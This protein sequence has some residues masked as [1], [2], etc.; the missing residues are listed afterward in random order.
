MRRF[1]PFDGQMTLLGIL[2]TVVEQV[3][4]AGDHETHGSD[5]G[6]RVR[7]LPRI[8]GMGTLSVGLEPA[9]KEG[10]EAPRAQGVVLNIEDHA[11]PPLQL[12][13]ELR[14]HA[15]CRVLETECANFAGPTGPQ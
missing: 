2:H 10:M 11:A 4:L 8:D 9:G 5:V 15:T 13:N 3:N 12:V 1:V 7:T 6:S 14:P